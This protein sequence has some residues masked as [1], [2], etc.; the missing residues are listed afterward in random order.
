M[1]SAVRAYGGWIV[2]LVGAVLCAVGWYGVSGEKHEARQLPYIASATV[3]GAALIVAGA[4]LVAARLRGGGGSDDALRRQVAELHALIL[5]PVGADG[6]AGETRA[7]E[8][9]D[10]AAGVANGGRTSG[11]SSAGAV[12]AGPGSAADG[13]GEGNVVASGDT[14][15]VSLR[16]GARYH[17]PDCELVRG[18]NGVFALRPKQAAELDLRPCALCDPDDTGAAPAAP[19]ASSSATPSGPSPG[20]APGSPAAPPS[21][22]PGDA[23]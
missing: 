11:G 20:P 23:D 18:K 21:A 10:G 13:S 7:G 22:A 3:P 1:R 9:R 17:R 19:S 5:E 12:A 14:P 15:F 16:G 8:T 6:G 4:V 2:V